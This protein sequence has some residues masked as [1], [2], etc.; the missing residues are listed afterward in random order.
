MSR[1]QESVGNGCSWKGRERAD[2][3]SLCKSEKCPK[4]NEKPL[5]GSKHTFEKQIFVSG[6]SFGHKVENGLERQD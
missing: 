6:G 3:E 2:H 1:V 4:G 5:R